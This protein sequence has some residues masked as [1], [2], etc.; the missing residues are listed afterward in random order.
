[1]SVQE[2]NQQLAQ[3]FG[4]PTPHGALVSTV[5]P[6]GPGEK[7]RLEAGDVITSVNG[8]KIE[9]SS[10]LPA[11]ISQLPPGSAGALGIWHDHKATE[12][13]VKTVLLEDSPAQ[14]A[15]ASGEDGGGKLGL[16][17]RPL[18]PDEQQELHTSGRLVVEDV[19]GPALAAGLQ[20]GR[21]G[22]G[23]QRGGRRHRGRSEARGCPGRAQ[24]GAVDAAR[25]CADLYSHR[26]GVNGFV[27]LKPRNQI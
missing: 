19:S 21:C 24:R 23:R 4:L 7:A 12:V 6:K 8:R 9:H 2:I 26:L 11:V 13:T 18:Q 27:V 16:A 25:G 10:D 1:M 5:E 20:A 3:S 22:A 15:R 17:V 14:A